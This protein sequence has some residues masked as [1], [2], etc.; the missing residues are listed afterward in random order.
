MWGDDVVVHVLVSHGRL[1]KL[2]RRSVR[3][4]CLVAFRRWRRNGGMCASRCCAA[5]SDCSVYYAYVC[6]SEVDVECLMR[7]NVETVVTSAFACPFI[8]RQV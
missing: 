3:C 2:Q 1:G 7:A 6:V 8:G 4:T 5:N